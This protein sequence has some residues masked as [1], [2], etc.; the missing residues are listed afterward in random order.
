M[1]RHG[2]FVAIVG[3]CAVAPLSAAP[4]EATAL[5]PAGVQRGQ[6]ATIS[7]LGSP[8]DAKT[9]VEVEGPGLTFSAGSKAGEFVASA[10][11]DAPPGVRW[12]R[13][14]N[15]E[16][17]SKPRP[18]FVGSLPELLEKEPNERVSEATLVPAPGAVVNGRLAQ[19]G[20]ADLMA[21]DL[22]AGQTLV[23]DLD[24]NVPLGS[25]MD[26]VMHLVDAQG[27]V[28]VQ[29]HDDV[30]LDPRI[31]YTAP[32]KGRY[33]VRFTAF[34]STPSTSLGM[35]GGEN[36][37]YRLTLTTGPLVDHA[38][39]L[40]TTEDQLSS[41]LLRGPNVDPRRKATLLPAFDSG[42]VRNV[43]DPQWPGTAQVRVVS[44][45]AV[46]QEPSSLDK[47]QGVSI[48][49]TISGCLD[50]PGDADVYQFTGKKG[51][52]GTARLEGR[53]LGFP[54][55]PTLSLVNAAGDE[56]ATIDDQGQTRDPVLNLA[57]GADG[58]YRVVV[59][60]LFGHGSPRHAYRLTLAWAEPDWKLTVA[61]TQF[62]LA[63]G[64][65]LEIPVTIERLG[66]MADAIEV[67]LVGAPET[68]VAAPVTSQA[69]D[70]SAKAVKLSVVN[71]GP[72]WSGRVRIVGRS[73]GA[74]SQ[75][76]VAGTTVESFDEPWTALWLTAAGK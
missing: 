48:P 7:V 3:A 64:K 71:K 66:G 47:P 43:F 2:I 20:D 56:T 76:R 42:A 18:F 53:S 55:D 38:W 8:G 72:A 16:G 9:R 45:F 11:A 34:S 39:P 67:R 25:P 12:L 46:E 63:A 73:Q 4:P 14:V 13:L 52:R 27:F 6:K 51:Q 23:A 60:D 29:N 41:V 17:A 57:I 33:V 30:T 54:L 62:V 68:I 58:D 44:S 5:F 21:I 70:A 15:A 61:D 35:N 36:F 65:T 59:R 32:R 50:R 49:V 10:S 28:L 19:A 75:E 22:E 1:A 74:M 37:I 24:A 26:A 69:K 40:A 31:V